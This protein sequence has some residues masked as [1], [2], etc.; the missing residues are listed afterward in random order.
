MFNGLNHDIFQQ[1]NAS[2]SLSMFSGFFEKQINN[3][4]NLFQNMLQTTLQQFFS[5][6]NSIPFFIIESSKIFFSKNS[7]FYTNSASLRIEKVKYF[8]LEYQ[9]K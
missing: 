9:Q 2:T 7:F 1:D 6:Q 8:D 5:N 3:M 4:I